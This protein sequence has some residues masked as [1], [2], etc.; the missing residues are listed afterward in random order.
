MSETRVIYEDVGPLTGCEC[1]AIGRSGCEAWP[2][3]EN[4][5]DIGFCAGIVAFRVW[6]VL[7]R[8]RSAHQRGLC[9]WHA[10]AWCKLHGLPWPPKGNDDAE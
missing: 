8:A 10:E 9:A 2:F 1:E 4:E 6:F 5:K 3:D 7:K